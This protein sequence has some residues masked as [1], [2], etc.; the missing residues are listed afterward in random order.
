MPADQRGLDQL[1]HRVARHPPVAEMDDLAV[2]VSFHADQVAQRNNI[3]FDLGAALDRRG[4]AVL[5]VY[6][7]GEAPS[8][9]FSHKL[10]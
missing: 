7:S 4:V 3:R 8:L 6:R 2:S 10:L 5:E 1:D 9:P